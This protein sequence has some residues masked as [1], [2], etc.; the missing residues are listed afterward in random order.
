MSIVKDV[1]DSIKA[2]SE[3]LQHIRTIAK[4]VNDGLAYLKLRHPEIQKDLVAMCAEIGTQVL[5]SLQR[6]LS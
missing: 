5:P 6:P 4:A 1:A 3:G 2:V